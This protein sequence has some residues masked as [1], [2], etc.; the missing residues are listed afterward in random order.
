VLPHRT[1]SP[2]AAAS[3]GDPAPVSVHVGHGP[4]DVGARSV[5]T[6]TQGL[7]APSAGG[8]VAPEEAAAVP[9]KKNR[10]PR[11]GQNMRACVSTRRRLHRDNMWRV[12]RIAKGKVALD[13]GQ[14]RSA[15]VSHSLEAVLEARKKNRIGRA[16]RATVPDV[17]YD[18][19]VR[20]A[21]CI[22]LD[23]NHDSVVEDF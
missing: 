16:L 21:Q 10:G 1:H 4:L 14:G 6:E 18:E 9:K 17:I 13:H 20:R 11:Q 23:Q 3:L 19:L 12:V 22:A 7:V 15:Y 2:A 5:R 8:Q